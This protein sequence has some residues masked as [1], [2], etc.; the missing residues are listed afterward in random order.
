MPNVGRK[1][2]KHKKFSG[3][4]NGPSRQRY[5]QYGTLEKHKIAHLIKYNGLTRAEA[6][7]LWHDS[8]QGRKK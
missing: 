6:Y 2:G 7:V 4:N 5:W 8:R 1:K 3:Q